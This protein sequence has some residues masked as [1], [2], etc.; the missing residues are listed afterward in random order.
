MAGAPPAYLWY[1]P[2]IMRSLLRLFP[3]L[4][5][6][7]FLGALGCDEA[8]SE[9]PDVVIL[10]TTTTTTT[11]AEP[12]P[13]PPT[14]PPPPTTTVEPTPAN[15]IVVVAAGSCVGLTSAVQCRDE[16]LCT[17]DATRVPCQT[18]E[19]AVEN[20]TSGVAVGSGTGEPGELFQLNGLASGA[21]TVR[22]H[23]VASDGESDDAIYNVAVSIP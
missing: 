18:I 22:Q 20:V 5:I 9:P 2:P 16:S 23:T 13:P 11:T 10:T 8:P 3:V 15:P 14:P 6:G 7:L 21:Y 12:S 4:L 17:L 1:R 19:W